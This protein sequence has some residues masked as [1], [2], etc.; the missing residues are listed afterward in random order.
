MDI[1]ALVVVAS[2]AKS[3]R[4]TCVY[5]LLKLEMRGARSLECTRSIR[6]AALI[7]RLAWTVLALVLSSVLILT[8]LRCGTILR[9]LRA[10]SSFLP[11]LGLLTHVLRLNTH[12]SPHKFK[13]L[14]YVRPPHV[15]RMSPDLVVARRSSGRLA[16]IDSYASAATVGWT[17]TG[18]PTYGP[19]VGKS[20]VVMQQVVA[21]GAA[22]FHAAVI[23]IAPLLLTHRV[24]STG[25]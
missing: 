25:V 5:S 14:I 9:L 20:L 19:S 7:A 15:S 4:L 23:S 10:W 6:A 3:C 12:E 1:N 13:Y 24:T 11:G 21:I 16:G 17:W 8:G 22:S 2:L 18:L